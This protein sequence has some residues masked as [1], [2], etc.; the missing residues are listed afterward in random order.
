[1]R[2]GELAAPGRA[3]VGGEAG[4]HWFS[5]PI[6][7][8]REPAAAGYEIQSLLSPFQVAKEI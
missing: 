3:R 8:S 7:L 5:V 1:M 6:A 2:M 4:V